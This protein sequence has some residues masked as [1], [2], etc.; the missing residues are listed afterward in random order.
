[1]EKQQMIDQAKNSLSPFETANVVDFLQHLTFKSAMDRPLLIAF[2]LLVAFYAVVKRSK[3]VLLFLFAAIAIMLLVKYTLS[4]E[5]V[6]SGMSLSATM[7][8]I[9]GGLAIGVALIYLIFIR[10]D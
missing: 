7:P 9:G 5:V 10:H 8:F 2:F 1:M 3:F 4:P 6:G